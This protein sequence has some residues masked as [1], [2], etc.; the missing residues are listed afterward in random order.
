MAKPRTIPDVRWNTREMQRGIKALGLVPPPPDGKNRDP[1]R[2]ARGGYYEAATL[3]GWL[4]YEAKLAIVL[5]GEKNT[6]TQEAHL[7]SVMRAALD[8]AP[9]YDT[10]VGP[11]HHGVTA[12]P[13]FPNIGH[14]RIA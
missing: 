13:A 5:E 14:L 4:A 7:H 8:A 9:D 11:F 12:R 1:K 2:E 10:L 3:E 6:W